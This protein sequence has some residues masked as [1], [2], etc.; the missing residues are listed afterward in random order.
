MI[1]DKPVVLLDLLL[2][3]YKTLRVEKKPILS[4]LSIKSSP[5]S[6]EGGGDQQMIPELLNK[7]FSAKST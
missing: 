3:I 7:A 4:L 1:S 5:G 6:E 2:A